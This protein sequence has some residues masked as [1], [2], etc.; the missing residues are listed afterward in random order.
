[1]AFERK[2]LPNGKANPQYVDLCDEDSPLAGQKFF[3]ASFA[4]PEK[5]LKN[6]EM[7]LFDKFVQQWDYSRSMS[8]FFDFLNFAAYKYNLKI[9]QL[10]ADFNEFLKEE[11]SRMDEHSVEDDYK[12][13]L[14]KNEDALNTTFNRQNAFQT[15]VRGVKVRG[16][17]NTQDEAEM[18]CKKLREVDPHHDIFV[19]PVGMWIPWDPD[20]YKTGRVEF[21]EEELNQLHKEKLKNEELAKQEF[22]TRVKTAK[23]KAVEDNIEKAKKSG[24]VL[25]QT[26]DEDGNLAGVRSQINFDDREVADAAS[27]SSD[28]YSQAL[29]NSD[30]IPELERVD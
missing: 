29:A 10:S 6:R 1:M 8:K 25:T 26:I 5:I 27:V 3:C 22:E 7:F 17:F 13:F 2:T 20:A 18:R 9:E 15:S 4:S 12:T 11:K 30:S 21:I 23:K 14:D 16:V 28:I 24:N 19:G